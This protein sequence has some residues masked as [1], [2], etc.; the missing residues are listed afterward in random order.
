MSDGNP[1]T[2]EPPP[3]TPPR[4]MHVLWCEGTPGIVE[5][6]NDKFRWTGRNWRGGLYRLLPPKDAY[7]LGYHYMYPADGRVDAIT[8]RRK[9]DA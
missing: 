3:G 6:F 9:S 1:G 7:R 2:T 4:T 5:P 8:C